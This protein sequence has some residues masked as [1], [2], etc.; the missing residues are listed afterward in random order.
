MVDA[1][2]GST[3]GE[4]NNSVPAYGGRQRRRRKDTNL[5]N[6]LTM[7]FTEVTKEPAD[8]LTYACMDIQWVRDR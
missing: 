3:E 4:Y 1:V 6:Q 5:A 7:E 8:S 2:A